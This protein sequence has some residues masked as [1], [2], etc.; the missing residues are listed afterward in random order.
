M[1]FGDGRPL[2]GYSWR[3]A[4]YFLATIHNTQ[5]MPVVAGSSGFHIFVAHWCMS[6]MPLNVDGAGL[7]D[8]RKWATTIAK[9]ALVSRTM[10]ETLRHQAVF[11]AGAFIVKYGEY[12][13][14]WEHQRE[15]HNGL[16]YTTCPAL[17]DAMSYG[18]R[19][20][21]NRSAYKTFNTVVQDDVLCFLRVYPSALRF[22]DGILRCRDRVS[23]FQLAISNERVPV[24]FIAK[25]VEL[26]LPMQTT[27]DVNGVPRDLQADLHAHSRRSGDRLKRLQALL[28][29]RNAGASDCIA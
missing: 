10:Y 21:F 5:K 25:L 11:V 4:H 16:N 9:C 27:I 1:S 14:D 28:P 6:F 12:N 8:L 26:G 22:D 17:F 2:F 3:P 19:V 15:W 24:A 13:M 23:V 7:A 18:H 20:P 29:H